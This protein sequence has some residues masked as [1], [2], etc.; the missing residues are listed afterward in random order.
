MA[1]RGSTSRVRAR[2]LRAGTL[3]ATVLVIFFATGAANAGSQEKAPEILLADFE[4][5]TPQGYE[6]VRAESSVQNSEEDAPSGKGYL[7][8]T[9]PAEG[10][11]PSE[12]TF[13]LQ[14]NVNLSR[15]KGV[16]A[17][18]WMSD[19]VDSWKFRWQLLD[20]AQEQIYQRMFKMDAAC[21]WVKKEWPLSVWRWSNR[22]IG[23]WSEG[24][25]VVL[26]IE[27]GEGEFR[28]DD[29]R[30]VPGERGKLSAMP[31]PDWVAKIAFP[32]EFR[33]IHKE[34]VF[35][36]TDDL[37]DLSDEDL[38]SISERVEPIRKWVRAT[39]E[40]ALRPTGSDA[41]V[42]LIIFK[43]ADGFKSFYDRLGEAWNVSIGAPGAGGY[44]VQDI[45]ASTYS[46]RY[47]ADRPVYFHELIHAVV[48]RELRL[49]PG[50]MAHSWLQEGIANYL[51]LCVY[52][53][54]IGRDMIV[55]NFSQ[56][57]TK[58]SFFRPLRELLTGRISTRNYLQLATLTAFLVQ[59]HPEWLD[60][61]A[62]GISSGRDLGKVLEEDLETDFEE[63]QEKWLAWGKGVFDPDSE[64]P[65]GPGTHFP[66]PEQWKKAEK[67]E[68][69]EGETAP[70]PPQG[71][72]NPPGKE[73]P[74]KAPKAQEF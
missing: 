74:Q 25:S 50:Q 14:E 27:V 21:G 23:D 72:D 43:D 60:K 59:E 19:K 69:A 45:A 53:Q 7:K 40:K 68:P 3:A 57:I 54:S 4:E 64:P 2:L 30:L 28:I 22:K 49:L 39:F 5:A 1:D 44:T 18:V 67:E 65:E 66:V 13:T 24:R 33:S 20:G 35:I 48:S 37:E 61:I 41:P 15:Y 70:E 51:Q 17:W 42:S 16:S 36:A 73:E 6:V 10:E 12:I 26:N 9:I 31:E 8:L 63:L 62:L 38:K 32:G 71:A 34:S 11:H 46:S 55:R 29:V 52:P 58:R 56:R 47:G